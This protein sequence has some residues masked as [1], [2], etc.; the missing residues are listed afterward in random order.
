MF[1]VPIQ[2]GVIDHKSINIENLLERKEEVLAYLSGDIISLLPPGG[3]IM[4]AATAQIFEQY[5][6]DLS[7]QRF[8][9]PKGASGS[10]GRPE[11]ISF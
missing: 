2:K 3:D 11:G 8:C 6:V 9:S 10:R 4:T 5:S 7:Q 1:N